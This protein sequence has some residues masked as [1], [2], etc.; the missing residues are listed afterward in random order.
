M[1]EVSKDGFL[2]YGGT[3]GRAH[4][5]A[6]RIVLSDESKRT[7]KKRAKKIEDPDA[8]EAVRKGISYLEITI[9]GTTRAVFTDGRWVVRPPLIGGKT[10]R[11]MIRMVS[12][13]YS[14]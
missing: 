8:Q 3:D 7:L 6:W 9:D 12:E 1:S 10:V 13:L 2:S 11:T 14:G 4:Y 5:T